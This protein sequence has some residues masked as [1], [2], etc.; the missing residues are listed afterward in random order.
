MA[1]ISL[2]AGFGVGYMN[3]RG[4]FDFVAGLFGGGDEKDGESVESN[5][6][7]AMTTGIYIGNVR[8]KPDVESDVVTTLEQNTEVYFLEDAG[9]WTLVELEDGREGYVATKFLTFV[10][11]YDLANDGEAAATETLLT[12]NGAYVILRSEASTEATPAG[13]IYKGDKVI[14]KGLNNS[15]YQVQ[16]ASGLSGYAS[17]DLLSEVD[18]TTATSL[19]V[20]NVIVS[21]EKANVRAS[22]TSDSELLTTLYSGDSAQYLVTDNGWYHVMLSDGTFGY[23]REDLGKLQ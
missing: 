13:V 9:D 3:Q 15:W 11:E 18:G 12:P 4:G 2:A 1:V 5:V 22:A 19:P 16:T 8:M 17:A 6:G 23:I 7:R 14:N 10:D 21:G 20:V